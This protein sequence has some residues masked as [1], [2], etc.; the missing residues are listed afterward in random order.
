METHLSIT[1]T[2]ENEREDFTDLNNTS[3]SDIEVSFSF[4]ESWQEP[5]SSA[6]HSVDDAA[7]SITFISFGFDRD[8]KLHDQVHDDESFGFTRL[9]LI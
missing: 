8:N 7:E 1:V 3:R 9:R 2:Y 5:D 6:V 4:D